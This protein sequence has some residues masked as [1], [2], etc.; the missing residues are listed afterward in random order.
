MSEHYLYP[1]SVLPTGFLFSKDYLDFISQNSIPDLEPWWFLCEFKDH[2]EYWLNELARQYPDLRFIPFAKL[3]DSDDF[4]CFDGGDRTGD[5]TVIYVHAFASQGWETRGS[6]MNFSEWL[7]K[8][9]DESTRYKA[10][11]AED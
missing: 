2:A 11:R 8:T 7:K 10:E 1:A 5:P 9:Y 3:E 4:A 6:V